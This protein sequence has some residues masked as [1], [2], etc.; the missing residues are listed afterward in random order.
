MEIIYLRKN[1]N[2]IPDLKKKVNILINKNIEM[3]INKE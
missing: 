1:K 3:Q 2:S